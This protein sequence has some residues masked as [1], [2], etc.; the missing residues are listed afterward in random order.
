[1]TKQESWMQPMDIWQ[2]TVSEPFL[3]YA[4]SMQVI[5]VPNQQMQKAITDAWSN[6]WN[7]LPQTN[8]FA[9]PKIEEKKSEN[10]SFDSLKDFNKMWEKNWS[11]YGLNPFKGYMEMFQKISEFWINFWKKSY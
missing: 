10:L 2:K 8:L 7:Q 11:S 1:M 6:M 3:I 4:K 9:L 5:F